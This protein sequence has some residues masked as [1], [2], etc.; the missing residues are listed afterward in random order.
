MIRTFRKIAIMIALTAL[1]AGTIHI[2]QTCPPQKIHILIRSDTGKTLI[3]HTLTDPKD[4]TP[5]RIMLDPSAPHYFTIDTFPPGV[6]CTF[7]GAQGNR[8]PSNPDLVCSCLLSGSS[9]Q[10]GT[11]NIRPGKWLL[12]TVRWEYPP[13]PM[14]TPPYPSETLCVKDPAKDLGIEVLGDI[15]ATDCP[16]TMK[17]QHYDRGEWR[18]QGADCNIHG[19]VKYMGDRLK[20]RIEYLGSGI[21]IHIEGKRIGDC[22]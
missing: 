7:K 15:L 14:F 22:P 3:D 8:L 13:N 16:Y 5:I 11:I 17:A 6:L 10:N 21:V 4:K 2:D 1:N 18:R 19:I 12:Q 20:E 9:E